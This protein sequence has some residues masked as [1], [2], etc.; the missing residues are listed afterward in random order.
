VNVKVGEWLSIPFHRRW[1]ILI[2]KNALQ[3]HMREWVKW[4]K[5]RAQKENGPSDDSPDEE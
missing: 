4:M 3:K 2:Y 5:E 1:V